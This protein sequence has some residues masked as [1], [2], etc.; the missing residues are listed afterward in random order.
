MGCPGR[1]GL[2]GLGGSDGAEAEIKQEAGER[3]RVLDLPEAGFELVDSPAHELDV[4]AGV[5]AR[6]AHGFY[7]FGDEEGHAL[8]REAGRRP[9]RRDL[10]PLPTAEAGLFLELPLPP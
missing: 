5:R 8:V 10:V 2:S 4:L 3:L 7:A 9:E 1:D 6:I